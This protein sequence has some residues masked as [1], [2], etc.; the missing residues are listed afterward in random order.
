VLEK[1]GVV[2]HQSIGRSS[3]ALPPSV[4]MVAL[5]GTDCC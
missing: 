1:L 2:V 5:E 3:T 4:A